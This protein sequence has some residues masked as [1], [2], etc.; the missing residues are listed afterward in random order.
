MTFARDIATII[1]FM[2]TEHGGRKGPA[3]SNY[4]P[5]FYYDGGDWDAVHEYPDVERVEPGQTV[6]ALLCF[7]SPEAHVGKLKPGTPFLIREGQK[8][9]G[10]GAVTKILALEE[11][12]R[13][14]AERKRNAG[15]G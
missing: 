4:R 8:V 9:V 3:F 2:P 6:R 15:A 12:A 7:L 10:Y 5:Q 1:T 11:S 13:R 14:V